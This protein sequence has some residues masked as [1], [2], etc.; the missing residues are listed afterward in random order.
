MIVQPK[1]SNNTVSTNYNPTSYALLSQTNLP[2]IDTNPTS[3]TSSI[4]T[5]YTHVNKQS[6]DNTNN[7]NQNSDTFNITNQTQNF[8]NIHNIP[9]NEFFY[10]PFSNDPIKIPFLTIASHNIQEKYNNK[11][12]DIIT[13]M[14]TKNIHILHICE[15]NLTRPKGEITYEQKFETQTYNINNP[16]NP[17]LTHTFYIINNPDPNRKGSGNAFILSSFIYKHKSKITTIESRYI[18]IN[19]CFKKRNNIKI[20]GIYIPPKS[21]P[22]LKETSYNEILSNFQSTIVQDTTKHIHT[23]SNTLTLLVKDFNIN[24]NSNNISTKQKTFLQS[25]KKYIS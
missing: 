13:N 18:T 12:S 9:I 25:L 24:P 15:T 19:L 10:I 7:N 3:S 5:N 23:N 20:I 4:N 8:N 2:H 6:H 21:S 22:S 16:I 17:N 14:I 1:E 11:L